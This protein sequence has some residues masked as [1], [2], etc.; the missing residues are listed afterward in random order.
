MVLFAQCVRYA[1]SKGVLYR[2]AHSATLRDGEQAALG[3][4]KDLCA[5][6]YMH[7]DLQITKA[8]PTAF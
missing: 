7:Y 5:I 4:I 1:V 8:A 3:L 6:R 2:L